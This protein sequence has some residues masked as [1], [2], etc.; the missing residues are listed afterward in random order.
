MVKI[1]DLDLTKADF[2]TIERPELRDE[3]LGGS[4]LAAKLFSESCSPSVSALSPEN[5][6]V[7]AIGPL[8]AYFPTMTKAVAV[9]KSPRTDEWGESHAGGRLGTALRFSGFDAIVIRGKSDH[10]IYLSI[11]D[12]AIRIRNAETLWGMRSHMTP[13]RIIREREPGSGR[14]SIIRIGR[15]GENLVTYASVN[16]DTY[17]HFGR[18]GLG[19][20]FGSK[21]LKAI[22]ISGSHD[23]PILDRKR[24]KEIYRKIW[25]RIVYKGEMKKYHD[26]GTPVN[27]LSLNEM[28]ALPTRNFSSGHFESADKISG[29]E[30][31]EKLL[32]RKISCMSCPV[33]CIHIAEDRKLF[34]EEHEYITSYI[35]YDYEPIYALGSNLGISSSEKLLRVLEAVE[36]AGLDAISAG[37]VLAY[38]TE[39]MEKNMISEKDTEGIHLEWDNADG[40][41]Q[42]IKAITERK[43]EFFKMLG[44]SPKLLIEQYKGG[45]LL[46]VMANNGIAGYHTGLA[47][48]VGHAIGLRHSHLDNAG[49]SL[50]QK[51]LKGSKMTP[52]KITAKLVEEEKFRQVFTS[53]VACLF[54][55]S[56]Y[57]PDLICECLNVIGIEKNVEELNEIGE[58][59]YKMKNAWR[60]EA[61]FDPHAIKLPGR[62][63]E[64]ITPNGKIDPDDFK[65]A[66][67]E[68]SR[69]V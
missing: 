37:V 13:G 30:F 51:I 21:N 3:V 25:N 34:S 41:I 66:I 4:G 67:A 31:A 58:R 69:I 23:F 8:N 59:I 7:I 43:G 65:R 22:V 60:M 48:L 64:T 38:A 1:L 57:D 46:T 33:G 16:V 6:V 39:L 52:E 61:G 56:V 19:A 9:F 53:L 24:F 35:S 15:A 68:Y 11:H 49:Y 55:R 50:D 44:E 32:V 12:E 29:H 63:V 5:V 17:R 45:D 26:Y 18:L 2:S 62:F 14:R 20:V 27:I 10:P 28:G 36:E 54:A 42:A 47:N 40:Y